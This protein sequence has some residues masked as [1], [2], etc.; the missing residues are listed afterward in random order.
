MAETGVRSLTTSYLEDG[1]M[2]SQTRT[3]FRKWKT[4]TPPSLATFGDSVGKKNNLHSQD[5]I[6]YLTMLLFCCRFQLL[7]FSCKLFL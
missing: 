5:I 1:Q 6:F 7:E 4:I 3:T 2:L